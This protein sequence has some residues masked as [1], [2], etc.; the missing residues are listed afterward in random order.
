MPV[1][2]AVARRGVI[3]NGKGLS[4]FLLL[5]PI[6]S[7]PQCIYRLTPYPNRPPLFPLKSSRSRGI[8]VRTN[9]GSAIDDTDSHRR[10]LLDPD[11]PGAVLRNSSAH[12]NLHSTARMHQRS[13]DHVTISAIPGLVERAQAGRQ[14]HLLNLLSPAI[15]DQ[16]LAI[17]Q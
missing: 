14:H 2:T 1:R 8:R 13:F 12:D 6:I 9:H 17:R 11:R 4:V 5:F 10:L 3:S 7:S 15:H 16:L